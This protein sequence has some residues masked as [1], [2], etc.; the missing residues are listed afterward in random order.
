MHPPGASNIVIPLQTKNIKTLL[1][2]IIIFYVALLVN[3][4]LLHCL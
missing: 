1:H 2:L 4:V 3:I